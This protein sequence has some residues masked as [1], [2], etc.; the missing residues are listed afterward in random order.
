MD[1]SWKD[2]F[3][4]KKE[5]YDLLFFINKERLKKKIYPP[6]GKVFRI[7]FEVPFKKIKVVI[8]GQD[9]YYNLNQANGLSFSV[10]RGISVPPSLNNIYKEIKNDI[11]NTVISKE[12]GCLSKWS[13]QGVF[14]LNCILTVEEGKPGS[15][16]NIGWEIFTNDII[17]LINRHHEG[18]I[19]LLWGKYA[20]SKKKIIDKSKHFVLEAPHPSPLSA[21]RGF[22]GCRHFSKTNRILTIQGKK[23]IDWSN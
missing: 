10:E 2:V 23:T 6:K 22:F 17:R 14:L 15:H 11:P 8:L 5:L 16:S 1:L 13:K 7:F 12:N 9:P 4:K 20:Q 19:F 21:Y 3:L 18:I